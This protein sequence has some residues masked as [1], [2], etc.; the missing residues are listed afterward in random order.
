[1]EQAAELRECSRRTRRS[2]VGETER[3]LD[4]PRRAGI[5]TVRTALVMDGKLPDDA[6]NTCFDRAFLPEDE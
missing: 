2:A 4:L 1:M 3:E 5:R 6:Y